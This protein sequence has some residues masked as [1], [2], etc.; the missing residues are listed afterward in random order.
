VG[1]GAGKGKE[2]LNLENLEVREGD[3]RRWEKKSLC[4]IR[5]GEMGVFARCEGLK[6]WCKRT[7][8][9]KIT[10]EDQDQGKREMA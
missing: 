3:V 6:T 2:R 10:K 8:P 9:G 5:E 1:G 4:T 7:L